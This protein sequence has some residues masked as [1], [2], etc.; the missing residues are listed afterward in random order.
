MMAE[1]TDMA[2]RSALLFSDLHLGWVPCRRA[3]ERLLRHLPQAAD[4]AELIV[5]AGDIL[6]I[7]RGAPGAAERE[8]IAEL[9]ALVE[10]WRREGREVVYVEG[11]HDPAQ[12]VRAREVFAEA[13][14]GG[15]LLADRWTHV[16]E[17]WQGERIR[18]IHGH[19]FEGDAWSP[20][21]YEGLGRHLLKQ[22]NL[23]YHKLMP[24]RRTYPWSMGWVVGGV[25]WVETA[26]WRR[27]LVEDT[28]HLQEGVDVLV[29][30]HFHFGPGDAP[31]G[32]VH[33]WRTGAWVAD[34]HKG[35]V[36]RMLRY[37]DGRFSR[38]TLEGDRWIAPGDGR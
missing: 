20:G 19:R 18:V 38:I 28:R 24:L 32:K 17:G 15:A 2:T 3:H 4:D 29:H 6:D 31:L 16:F 7:H 8:R 26:L 9:A 35:T 23:L 30:G 5:L 12:E 11:N 34:G 36:N 22:E 14:P 21:A 1:I 37:R 13:D 27:R 25:G 33:S 10:G